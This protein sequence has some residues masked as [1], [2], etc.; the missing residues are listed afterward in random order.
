MSFWL[1][2][3]FLNIRKHNFNVIF[4]KNTNTSLNIRMKD[5]NWNTLPYPLYSQVYQII[6]HIQGIFC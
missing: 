2:Q 6:T 5:D 1:K 4:V 3:F